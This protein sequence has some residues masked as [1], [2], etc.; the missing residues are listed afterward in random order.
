MIESEQS[1]RANKH[2][3]SHFFFD[4]LKNNIDD[5]LTVK[6]VVCNVSGDQGG[7]LEGHRDS[8]RTPVGSRRALIGSKG[9]GTEV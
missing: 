2:S 4:T 8:R 5:T 3:I 7:R 6:W 9:G 1:T